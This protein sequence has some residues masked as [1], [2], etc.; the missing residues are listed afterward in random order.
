MKASTAIIRLCLSAM[1]AFAKVNEHDRRGD[2]RGHNGRE[3]HS[4]PEPLLGLG[5][6]SA[7]AVGGV[8]KEP[9][10]WGDAA[11]QFGLGAPVIE[12]LRRSAGRRSA[13]PSRP[14]CGQA[15]IG[16]FHF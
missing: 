8:L 16:H 15:E 14:A 11:D 1:P 13:A 6:P 10:F 12:I 5:I 2:D 9:K 3:Y 7:L 4:A